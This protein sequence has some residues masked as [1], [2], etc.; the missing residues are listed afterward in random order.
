[1]Q[2]DKTVRSAVID[3]SAV[4]LSCVIYILAKLKCAVSSEISI[5]QQDK[6]HGEYVSGTENWESACAKGKLRF[7]SVRLYIL[8]KKKK[9]VQTIQTDCILNDAIKSLSLLFL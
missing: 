6:S 1:M 4:Y 8:K 5:S 2:P 3:Y 9:N 7:L